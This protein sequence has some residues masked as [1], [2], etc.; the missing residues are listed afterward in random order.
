[1][2]H[3]AIP[4]FLTVWGTETNHL[5]SIQC[6]W[7]EVSKYERSLWFQ[8]A[9]IPMPCLPAP[10]PI[11]RVWDFFLKQNCTTSRS[12]L[13][14]YD[15]LS[16]PSGKAQTPK[17]GRIGPLGFWPVLSASSLTSSPTVSHV[18]APVTP[19]TSPSVSC[20]C[21][22]AYAVPS[23]WKALPFFSMPHPLRGLNA[24]S[25]VKLSLI[26]PG[27]YGLRPLYFTCSRDSYSRSRS[28]CSI[29]L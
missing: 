29:M 28:P 11:S 17:T 9:S 16:L 2:G 7:S 4:E 8:E 18:R 1:M 6:D 24:T 5:V 26:H 25:S 20:L 3:D 27:S 15:G 22:F 19:H 14:T 10:V 13:E 23:A 12:C 21:A